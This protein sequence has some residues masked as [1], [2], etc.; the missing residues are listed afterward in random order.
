MVGSDEHL[1]KHNASKNS[2]TCSTA[3][4]KMSTISL[5]AGS[6]QGTNELAYCVTLLSRATYSVQSNKQDKARTMAPSWTGQLDSEDWLVYREE[7]YIY[8]Y[9]NIRGPRSF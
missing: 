5:V 3:C 1:D 2:S 6:D 7:L 9:L 8:I 4:R